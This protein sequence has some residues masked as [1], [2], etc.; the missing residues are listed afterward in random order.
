MGDDYLFGCGRLFARK[1][2]VPNSLS[3]SHANTMQNIK[4]ILCIL[5]NV[6]TMHAYWVLVGHCSLAWQELCVHEHNSTKLPKTILCV[7]V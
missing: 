4:N 6:L 2:V 3:L 7:Y 1:S 5:S